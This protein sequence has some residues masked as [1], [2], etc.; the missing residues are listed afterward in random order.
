MIQK[1]FWGC[2]YVLFLGLFFVASITLTIV[3]VNVLRNARVS[4][5]W[6]TTTGEVVASSVRASSDSDGTTY[7]ADVSYSYVVDDHRYVSDTVS[8][9]EYG[10][11]DRSHAEEVVAR[12]PVGKRVTVYYNP[13]LPETAVLEPGV[14]WSSYF[15]LAMGLCFLSVTSIVTIALFIGKISAPFL[16]VFTL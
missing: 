15:P 5:G 16:R 4:E 2:F 9:G 11:S 8:F 13:E 1:L 7:Y 14:T 12:Y 3:G 10:S 6:P